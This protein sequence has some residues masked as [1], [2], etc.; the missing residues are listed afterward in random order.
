MYAIGWKL[1]LGALLL[2][3]ALLRPD[4]AAVAETVD[5]ELVLAVDVSRSIDDEEFTLQRQG[6]ARAF[7]HPAVIRAIQ[8]NP[9]RKIAVIFIEWSG[10]DFQKVV[11]PWTT[12]SDGES[13]ALFGEAILRQPRSFHGWT[14]ISGAIDFAIQQ[15][16]RGGYE[17]ERRVIDVSGDGINNSGRPT[18]EARDAAVAAGIVINGLVIMNDRP[19]S[20][21]LQSPQPPLDQYYREQVVGGPGAFVI[22]IADFSTFAY[23]I[24]NKL[25]KEIAADPA[26]AENA[27]AMLGPP[28]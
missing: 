21:L 11:V 10:Y 28:R 12:I 18:T 20:G 9:Q 1:R 16:G 24:V 6:Y 25:V 13:G 14:S 7:A 27:L 5:L 19:G 15:F 2:A 4:G 26:A 23:A 17:A 3:G 22:A 8:A